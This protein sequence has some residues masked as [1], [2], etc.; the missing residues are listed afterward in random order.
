MRRGSQSRTTPSMV[1]SMPRPVLRALYLRILAARVVAGLACSALGG[2]AH[3]PPAAQSLEGAGGA[4][5]IVN[6][7]SGD[8]LFL[9]QFCGGV[10]IDRITVATA[11]HCVTSPDGA[12]IH[13]VGGAQ[14]LCDPSES[15]RQIAAVSGTEVAPNTDGLVT[16]LHLEQEIDAEGPREFERPATIYAVGWGRAS[17]AGVPPC[18]VRSVQLKST[19]PSECSTLAGALTPKQYVCT[20]PVRDENTCDGDSGGPVYVVGDEGRLEQIA[21]TM[22]GLGCSADSP[23]LNVLLD[24]PALR[25]SDW[26][27]NRG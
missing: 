5:A 24:I 18:T 11:T 7:S 1:P 3:S 13:V 22:S 27:L 21:M 20:L 4:V 17:T 8:D 12:T 16:I 9:G 26:A 10:I 2:C 6:A 14:D 19:D 23:G 25:T 15:G